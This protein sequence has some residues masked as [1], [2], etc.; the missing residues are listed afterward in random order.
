M[1]LVR[2]P[3]RP[4]PQRSNP[5]LQASG[6]V[7]GYRGVAVAGHDIADGGRCVPLPEAET[8]G[9]GRGPYGDVLRGR[10]KGYFSPA[11]RCAVP[12]ARIEKTLLVEHMKLVCRSRTRN[13]VNVASTVLG[14]QQLSA[15]FHKFL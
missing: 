5:I 4:S 14:T 7:G 6:G 2:L 8:L 1:T 3:P 15:P 11:G 10:R 12:P 9:P 13:Q